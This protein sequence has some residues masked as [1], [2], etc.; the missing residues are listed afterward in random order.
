MIR[1]GYHFPINVASEG[2]T[3]RVAPVFS[4]KGWLPD[5]SMWDLPKI[6]DIIDSAKRTVRVQVL[7]YASAGQG[8]YFDELESALRRAAA[9]KVNVQ[10]LVSDWSK[11]KG[12]IEGLKSL[13]AIPGIDVKMVT[14]PPWSGGFIS[15]AR[16]IHAKY[17]IAD[18]ERS[19]VGTSNW[20]R[21]YFYNSRNVGMLI[22]SARVGARLDRFFLDNWDGPY[23]ERVD[24]CTNYEPPKTH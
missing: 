11:R 5:E 19:W 6:V 20:E 2:E 7:T 16:V 24:L 1:G 17:V 8:G 4:P 15:Y 10:L 22:D 3:A 14:I 9:R 18:G 21:G 13:Q 23:S 12:T